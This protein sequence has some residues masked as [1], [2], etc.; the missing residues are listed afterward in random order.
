MNVRVCDC[1]VLGFVTALFLIFVDGF[2]FDHPPD[3]LPDCSTVRVPKIRTIFGVV[4][5]L[6]LLAGKNILSNTHNMFLYVFYLVAC[7][8]PLLRFG[9]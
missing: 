3:E 2:F 7:I 5:M 8:R 9:L 6:K 1:S 4:G